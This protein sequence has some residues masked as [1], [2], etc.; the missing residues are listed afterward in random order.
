[1]TDKS[2]I[3]LVNPAGCSGQDKNNEWKYREGNPTVGK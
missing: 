2:K 3:Q 1:M